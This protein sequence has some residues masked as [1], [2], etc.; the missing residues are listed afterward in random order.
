MT[1]R[2]VLDGLLSAVLIN[3]SESSVFSIQDLV[4]DSF[5]IIK[6]NKIQLLNPENRE[7]GL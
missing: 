5:K 7:Q 2:S 6:M 4:H 1:T 3:L